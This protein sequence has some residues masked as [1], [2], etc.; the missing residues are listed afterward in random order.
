M[1]ALLGCGACGKETTGPT[2]SLTLAV[3][4]SPVTFTVRPPTSEP[5]PV[6]PC[7]S[8]L[9]ARWTLVVN[10]TAAGDLE[11]ATMNLRNRVTGFVY[12]NRRLDADQLAT[13]VSTHLEPGMNVA[14]AQAFLETMPAQL[15]SAEPLLLRLEVTLVAHGQAVT[16]AIEPPFSPAP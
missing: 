16:A 3:V 13:Q 4:P 11:S 6:S 5:N 7:C 2:P 14:I 15:S 10:T 9:A 12:V 8:I 1:G